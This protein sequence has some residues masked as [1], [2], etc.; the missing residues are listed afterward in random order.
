MTAFQFRCTECATPYGEDDV[1]LVCPACAAK[2]EPGG[3]TRGVLEVEIDQLPTSWPDALPSHPDFLTAFLPLPSAEH[4]PPLPVGGTPLLDVPPLRRAL[5]MRR[6]WVKD[7]TRN[8]SG[9]TKDRASLLVVA[10]AREY[11]YDTVAAASTGNA[12]T[13]LAA[14]SAA[15][16]T[17][18]I[19]FVPAAAP[20]AKLVQMLSYGA[21]VLPIDG[22]YDDA[23]E[24]CLAACE[25]FGWYN[26]NT[27]LNPFTIEGKKTAGLEIALSMAPEVPD[28]V[29]VPTGDGV[30]LAG[31]A[32]GFR[33]LERSGLIDRVPRLIA[34]QPEG[35]AAIVTA[36]KE[37][38]ETV[39][40]VPGAHSVAD[41]L[42]VEAPRNALQCMSVIRASGGSGV[43]VP[44][45]AILESIPRLAR[46]SGVF[47]EPSAAAGLAGLEVALAEALVKRDERVVLLVTGS[48]LKDVGAAARAVERPEVIEP[49]LEAVAG[50]V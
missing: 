36:L 17:R 46:L 38:S 14:V 45:P 5:E 6:L 41:S 1:R 22:T 47:A 15:A 35:A 13:A 8:P 27:A 16:G 28:A 34:V 33:D 48:G 29:L 9:S 49:T 50:R 12:A 39:S 37:V 42:T 3:V 10:K 7:D 25:E 26:R 4:L 43:A 24:L 20:E 18:A 32:K 2:Q 21:T 30:I 44:D 40:P 11:G 23:F 31:A 19:L